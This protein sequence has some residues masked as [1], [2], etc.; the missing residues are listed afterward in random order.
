MIETESVSLSESQAFWHYSIVLFFLIIPGLTTFDVVMDYINGNVHHRSF[1]K[2]FLSYIWILPAVVFYFIQKSKL[3]MKTINY[4][5]DENTFRKAVEDTAKE[6]EWNVQEM[7]DNWV[8]A[9]SGFSWKSWGERI[10]IVRSND[11][12]LF[13]SMC[14]PENI[15]S[16]ASYGMNKLNRKV[17]IDYLKKN[18]TIAQIQN[19]QIDL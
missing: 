14:D 5:V 11:K 3:K 6:L 7:T 19:D 13:N 9:I 15:S 18:Q 4:Y 2:I 8:I 1:G 16:V 12:V 17:F 10:T